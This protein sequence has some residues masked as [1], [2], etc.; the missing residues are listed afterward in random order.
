[1]WIVAALGSVC[2]SNIAHAD[3]A[4]N[5]FHVVDF[6][7]SLRSVMGQSLLSA[8]VDMVNTTDGIVL[9]NI[10]PQGAAFSDGS[11][12]SGQTVD[13]LRAAST[14]TIAM[15][16]CEGA[17]SLN[18][19]VSRVSFWEDILPPSPNQSGPDQRAQVA[20]GLEQVLEAMQNPPSIQTPG[21]MRAPH[22][23]FHGLTFE[24]TSGDMHESLSFLNEDS[25]DP[26]DSLKIVWT[27][28]DTAVCPVKSNQ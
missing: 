17:S 16:T 5:I 10:T 20:L 19:K 15:S 21:S 14:V 12:K 26:G 23:G 24:Y 28:L 8:A 2:L 3:D 7:Q 6:M 27:I 9:Q 4:P 18:D 1:L 25:S 13:Q 11:K 22:D